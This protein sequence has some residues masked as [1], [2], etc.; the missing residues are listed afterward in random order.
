MKRD[1]IKAGALRPNHYELAS[2]DALKDETSERTYSKA[3]MKA[4]KE[5]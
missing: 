5:Y 1:G 4:A 3:V 2:L